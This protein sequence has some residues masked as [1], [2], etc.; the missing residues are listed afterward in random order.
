MY[1]KFLIFN[2]YFR[3]LEVY[4]GN[5]QTTFSPSSGQPDVKVTIQS[6][7][8][9]SASLPKNLF[10]AYVNISE[11]QFVKKD[12]LGIIFSNHHVAITSDVIKVIA[13]GGSQRK[14]LAIDDP[15]DMLY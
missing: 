13:R 1:K 10:F 7:F 5:D 6:N 3:W 9:Q 4:P 11:S 8:M 14:P 15:E 12:K 2:C